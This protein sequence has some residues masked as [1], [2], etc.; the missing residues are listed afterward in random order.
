[1]AGATASSRAMS[2]GTTDRAEIAPERI[3]S[4]HA[5]STDGVG[6]ESRLIALAAWIRDYYGATM[7]QALKTVIP[8]RK[9]GKTKREKAGTAGGI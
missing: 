4:I 5:V 3:K 8:V 7:I 1:M 9:K 2:I 6:V